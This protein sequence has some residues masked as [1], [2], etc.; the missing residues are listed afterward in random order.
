M[1]TPKNFKPGEIKTIVFDFGNVILD[2]D[3]PH[4]IGEFVKLGARPENTS[5]KDPLFERQERGEYP[6]ESFFAA[7]RSR[8]P[9]GCPEVTDE[10][11]AAAWNSILHKPA[12]P[13]RVALLNQLR[14]DGYRLILLSNTNDIHREFFFN[15]FFEEMGVELDKFFDKTFF[16]DKLRC[17]KPEPLIYK[18][19][20]EE[21][22]LVPAT[23][24]FIDDKAENTAAAEKYAGW[25]TH[26]ISVGNETILDL[27]VQTE[28]AP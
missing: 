26:T 1:L 28:T 19:V 27:F 16:S 18:I 2:L 7:L 12:D 23:T 20:T 10:Q 13:R 14:A 15:K 25:R 21:A 5:E 17:R 6:R 24:L 11:L 22:R 4:C 8:A 3:I 9:E